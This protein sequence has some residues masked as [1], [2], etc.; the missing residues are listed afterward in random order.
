[1]KASV[2]GGE[3][4]WGNDVVLNPWIELVDPEHERKQKVVIFSGQLGG[5]SET[6]K[7]PA[8]IDVEL[9]FKGDNFTLLIGYDFYADGDLPDRAGGPRTIPLTA[10]PNLVE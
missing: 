6:A 5:G 1:M 9:P 4:R 10:P 8:E 7:G 3:L 2:Y